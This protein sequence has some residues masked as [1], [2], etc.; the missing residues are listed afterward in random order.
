MSKKTRIEAGD[1]P[2]Y[3][4]SLSNSLEYV[5]SIIFF[6]TCA[7]LVPCFSAILFN[8]SRYIGGKYACI[9]TVFSLIYRAFAAFLAAVYGRF[10][11]AYIYSTPCIKQ[12]CAKQK[13]IH[14]YTKITIHRYFTPLSTC[15]KFPVVYSCMACYTIVIVAGTTTKS[16]S[17][18]LNPKNPALA[19]IKHGI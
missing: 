12:Y 9:D 16:Y 5:V 15:Y 17:P 14:E 6:S 1:T 8:F 10:P 7:L 19:S 3:C 13:Y 4:Y 18:R 2:I 11:M